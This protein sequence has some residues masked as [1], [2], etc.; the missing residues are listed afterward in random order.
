MKTKERVKKREYIKDDF[1]IER[2][3]YENQQA[4]L[5]VVLVEKWGMIAAT[6]DGEDSAGRQRGK[7]MEVGEVVERACEMSEQLY[8][9]FEV[10]DWM[11]TVP[12][13]PKVA[14]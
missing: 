6:T 9:A 11:L 7:L 14:K 1:I 10:R 4:R 2:P 8:Q 3:Q 13:E 12:L 5:A